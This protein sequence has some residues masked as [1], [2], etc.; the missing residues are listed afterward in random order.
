MGL[1]SQ[2]N[3]SEEEKKAKVDQIR[4]KIRDKYDIKPINKVTPKILSKNVREISYP[5]MLGN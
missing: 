3:S 4:S 1:I 2:Q 5:K